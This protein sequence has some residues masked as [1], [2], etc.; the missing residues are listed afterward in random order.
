MLVSGMGIPETDTW[1]VVALGRDHAWRTGL[2]GRSRGD[3]SWKTDLGD[4]RDLEDET[5]RSSWAKRQHELME[6]SCDGGPPSYAEL[7]VMW[8]TLIVLICTDCFV[9]LSR[10][11]A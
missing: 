8:E 11:T 4:L 3:S 10:I 9:S 2:H 6:P 1:I 7:R 5:V